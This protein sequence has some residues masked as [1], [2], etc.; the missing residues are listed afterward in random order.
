[1]V[2]VNVPDTIESVAEDPADDMVASARS[3]RR[4]YHLAVGERLQPLDGQQ[5]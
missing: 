3:A 4:L 1:M 2:R 5:D